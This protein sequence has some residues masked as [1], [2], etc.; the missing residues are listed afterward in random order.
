MRA[1]NSNVAADGTD[2]RQRLLSSQTTLGF[3]RMPHKSIQ[4][5]VLCL[6]YLCIFHIYG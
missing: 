6:C 4:E 2:E 1:E 3:K 5:K